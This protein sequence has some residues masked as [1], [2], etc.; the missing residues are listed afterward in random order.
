MKSTPKKEPA[1]IVVVG[2]GNLLLKD[3]GVGVHIVRELQRMS[4]PAE[5]EVRDGGV[6]GIDLLDSLERASHAVLVDAAE[7]GL[8]PG[9]VR[10]FKPDEVRPGADAPRFSSHDLGLPEVLKLAQELG[11]S[12]EEVIIIG[13]QPKEITWSTELSPEIQAAVPEAID[14]IL[15]EIRRILD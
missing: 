13:I 2:V 7:M 12:P 10:R 15:A 6:G 4:L 11:R 8:E 5:V 9:T 14:K 1:K 3:E